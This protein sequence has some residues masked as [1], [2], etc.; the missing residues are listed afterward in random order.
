MVKKIVI[1]GCSGHIGSVLREQLGE[2]YDLYGIDIAESDYP[3]FSRIDVA[4]NYDGLREVLEDKDAI[5]HLAWDGR[6]NFESDVAIPENRMMIENVY[7]A[8]IDA[9][10]PQVIMASSIHAADGYIDR[11]KINALIARK[12]LNELRSF[13]L[14][15]SEQ[16]A[17][18]NPYGKT[19]LWMEGLGRTYAQKGLTVIC[20][21]FGA[22]GSDYRASRDDGRCYWLSPRDCGQ[23]V[24]KCIE[25]EEIPQF[26]IFFGVSNNTY[27]LVDI[28]DARNVLHYAPQDNAEDF[29]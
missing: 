9:N 4:R 27:N 12:S 23:L 16:S 29:Q 15:K 24:R 10:V 21:R 22:V 18:Q 8:A 14:L 13:P 26:S 1:T 6:E 25:I 20:L 3:H 7:R 19:K 2:A 17:P 28:S 5:I 11:K